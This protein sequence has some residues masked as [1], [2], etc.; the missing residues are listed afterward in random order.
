MNA[1]KGPNGDTLDPSWPPSTRAARG[2]AP[3]RVGGGLGWRINADG[4]LPRAAL[5]G[6]CVFPAQEQVIL[7]SYG[8]KSAGL[9]RYMQYIH[10]IHAYTYDTYRYMQYTQIQYDACKK[11]EYM[12]ATCTCCDIHSIYPNTYAY[13]MYVCCLY[14]HIWMY[15]HVSMRLATLPAKT[16]YNICTYMHIHTWYMQHTLFIQTIK[17]TR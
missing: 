3:K 11:S 5:S 7:T 17:C 1:H 8:R 16:T 6:V 15:M 4:H 14:V 2:G 9:G 12:H 10:I 13:I